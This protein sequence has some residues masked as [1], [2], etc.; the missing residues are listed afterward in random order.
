M[1]IYAFGDI[2]GEFFK[3]KKL[4]KKLAP[5]KDSQLVFLGDYIDRGN[6]IF[7][8]IEFLVNLSKYYDCVFIKGNHEDMF[9]KYMLGEDQDMYKNNGGLNTIDSYKKHN[10]DISRF[11]YYRHRR[12]PKSHIAFFKNNNIYYETE[13]YIFVHAGV[14]PNTPMENQPDDILLW[15]RT[16][17]SIEY[18]GKPVVYGHMANNMIL[19]EEY[20][21]CIDTGACFKYLGN[22]TC[23]ELPNRIFTQQK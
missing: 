19:N 18:R 8:T 17:S 22:L 16:F 4:I 12:M 5:E 13:D 6:L 20:K 7:E 23:V 21:I 3:L 14:H 11:T 15:D 10:W 2:H 9:E 1:K